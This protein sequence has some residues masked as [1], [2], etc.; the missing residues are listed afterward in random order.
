MAVAGLLL[1]ATAGRFLVNF[2][3]D[4]GVLRERSHLKARTV[5]VAE[6]L[7]L[8]SIRTLTGRSADQ[9][10]PAFR[11]LAARLTGFRTAHGDVRFIY[12]MGLQDDEVIFLLDSADPSSIDYSPPGEVYSEAS[13]ELI[14]S[15]GTGEPFVEGPLTDRWGTW[16]SGLVPIID[17]AESRA[18][19]VLGM[20]IDAARWRVNVGI[21]RG[22]AYLVTGLLAWMVVFF[23]GRFHRRLTKRGYSSLL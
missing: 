15:F 12:L 5:A 21:C 2:A 16:V 22:V 3:T 17:P 13:P 1:V 14:G 9:R 7:D 23:S 8:E 6:S 4:H 10:T 18:I 11:Q 20:D 19:A